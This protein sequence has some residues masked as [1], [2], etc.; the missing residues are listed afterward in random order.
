MPSA[1]LLDADGTLIDAVYQHTLTWQRA[2]ARHGYSV[3]AWRCHRH[4]GMGGDQIVTA[5]AGEEAEEEDGESL[6]ETEGALFDE[7]IDEVQGLPGARDL[8]EALKQRGL[9]VVVASSGSESHIE[10]HLGELG[11]AETIDGYTTS[12]EVD[13]TKPHPDLIETALERAGT[14][15]AVMLGDSTWDVEA[16]ERAGIE[17]VG[18]LCG[19]FSEREL[20][21]AGAAAVYA[22]PAELCEQLG[23]SPFCR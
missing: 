20:R 6:R 1:A 21:E 17:T 18:L 4:I 23:D 7:L 10:R 3:P 5:L 16:A 12:D 15:D 2:F 11:I 22:T 8:V 19:G 13:R 14:R 9:T